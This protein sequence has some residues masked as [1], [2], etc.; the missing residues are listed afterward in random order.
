MSL[1][2]KNNTHTF[3]I[4]KSVK[5]EKITLKLISSK[6]CLFNNKIHLLVNQK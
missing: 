3:G 5:K 2:C 6:E 4:Q 1:R